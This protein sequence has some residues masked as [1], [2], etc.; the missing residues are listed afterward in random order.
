MSV[1]PKSFLEK[2][3]VI[4]E[5]YSTKNNPNAKKERDTRARG[6]RKEGYQVQIETFHFDTAEVFTLTAARE[7]KG[8][9]PK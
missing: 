4:E 6:L 9:D 2:H 1:Y 8:G 5:R 7:K 3:D